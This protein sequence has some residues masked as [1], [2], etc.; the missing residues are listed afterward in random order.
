MINAKFGLIA[1]PM[2]FMMMCVPTGVQACMG[3]EPGHTWF[4][5][6]MNA[7]AHN[8]T[9][10]SFVVEKSAAYVHVQYQQNSLVY[11]LNDEA[12]GNFTA[13]KP[14]AMVFNS[15]QGHFQVN[16]TEGK[17]WV[18]LDNR[19]VDSAASQQIS[20]ERY[21]LKETGGCGEPF[22]PNPMIPGPSSGM[23]AVTMIV[24]ALVALVIKKRPN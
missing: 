18:V 9:A 4:D 10:R 24:A 19:G 16:L 3:G 20:V 11:I 17:Y 14:C 12:M 5:Q 13:G 6:T 8:Y 2:I 23:V 7:T 15:T 21:A 1:I 22:G